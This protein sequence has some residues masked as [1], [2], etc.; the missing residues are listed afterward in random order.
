MVEL[1]LLF[2]KSSVLFSDHSNRSVIRYGKDSKSEII[3]QM[4]FGY[5]C[6]RINCLEYKTDK[7]KNPKNLSNISI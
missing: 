3:L 1:V 4:W 6:G 5:N 7:N 2:A